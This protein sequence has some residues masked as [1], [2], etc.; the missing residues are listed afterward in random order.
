MVNADPS[1]I[2]RNRTA[3]NT[4]ER[5]RVI[6]IAD[7]PD[8]RALRVKLAAAYRILARLGLD[9]GLAGHI[10]LRMPDAPDYFWVNPLASCSARSRLTTWCWSTTKEKS[11]TVGP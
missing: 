8:C 5:E 9:D 3:S 2:V 10:S 6:A 7:S 11:S 1:T 4:A